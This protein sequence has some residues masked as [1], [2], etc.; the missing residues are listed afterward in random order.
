M[1][2]IAIACFHWLI[3]GAV[4]AVNHCSLQLDNN[5]LIQ[6]FNAYTGIII[7]EREISVAVTKYS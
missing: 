3:D 6:P 4:H 5:L 2:L 7:K 1:V